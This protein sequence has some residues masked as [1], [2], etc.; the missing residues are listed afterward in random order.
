MAIQMLSLREKLAYC[1]GG[2]A[3]NY[4]GNALNLLAIP[5]FSIGLG[6]EAWKIGL[7]MGIPRIWD[8]ITD[9]IM[10][11]ISDSWRGRWGRRK[12]FLLWGSLAAGIS[13]ALLWLPGLDWSKDA[14]FWW[15]LGLSLVYY[16]AFT[17]FSIPFLA[18]GPEIAATAES[19]TSLQSLRAFISAIFSLAMPWFYAACFWKWE[20]LSGSGPLMQ[21]LTEVVLYKGAEGE[22]GGYRIVGFGL[23]A[24]MTVLGLAT[25]ACRENPL[26]AAP[27]L[28]GFRTSLK[29]V[30]ANRPFV[31]LSATLLT[32]FLG[33]F[34]V[35]PMATYVNIYHIYG[36]DKAAASAML[37]QVGT[38]QSLLGIATVP[39]LWWLIRK[40]GAVRMFQTFML[41]TALSFGIKYWTY[42]PAYPWLQLLP[43]TLWQ[44]AWSGTMLT[45]NVI[46]GD[47][48]DYDEYLTG[49]RREGIYGAVNQMLFKIA[50]G[51]STAL[52]G[53]L[54]DFSGIMPQASTQTT[55]AVWLLRIEFSF[56]PF[57][58]MLV[59]LAV[60]QFYPL[61]D[62][63]AN[64]IR[65]ELK[66][67]R[68][69]A[70]ASP[71]SSVIA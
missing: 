14:I 62:R 46:L 33:I 54:L 19:R 28:G 3:N 38:V 65:A 51:V 5:I 71:A 56:V 61:G 12:P 58:I 59:S 29:A 50:I 24:V 39:L 40:F 48:C 68:S 10:G 20:A 49:L 44:L 47:I 17:V 1:L 32:T 31:L 7:A 16:T 37:A 66:E 18:L 55:A 21:R 25:L 41:V 11:H 26:G 42:T 2:V 60:F 23:A 22:L 4:M 27:Q 52:S 63:R 70:Q 43:L 57:A 64:E 35:M 30:L 69:A 45:F 36:G 13:F 8:A 9:P 53:L 15:F 67:R 34:L 6:V